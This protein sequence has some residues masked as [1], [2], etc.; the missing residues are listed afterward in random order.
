MKSIILPVIIF[1]FTAFSAFSAPLESLVS[2]AHAAQLR[3]SGEIVMQTQLRNPVPGLVPNNSDL[4]RHVNAVMSSLNPGTIV[5]ALCLYKKPAPFHTSVNSWDAE[6]KTGVFNQMLAIS[7]LTGTQ[8]YSASR[9]TMRTFYESSVIID[10]PSTRNP[11]A[12]PVFSQPPAAL[13]LYARQKDLTFG[14]NIYRYDCVNTRDAVFFTQENV[15]SLNYGI[16]PAVGRGNLRSIVAVIDCGD[17]ILIYIVSMAR[18]FSVPGIGERITNSF[19]NRTEAVLKWLTGRLDRE[20][21][22]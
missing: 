19:S 3:S 5:E 4:R 13:S 10:G 21:F 16:I 8:Y 14:D 17:S 7:T 12:D 22:N 6:Q 2:A 9:N 11:L 1:S 20:L 15:T 18:T